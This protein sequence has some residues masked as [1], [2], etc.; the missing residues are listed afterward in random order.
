M[1]F[2]LLALF[3][4]FTNQPFY[5]RVVIK[6]LII[7]WAVFVC[8]S[9]IVIGAHFASDVIFGAFII[10]VAYLFSINKANKTLKVETD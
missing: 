5:K 1:G 3:V 8:L 10:I 6:G 4:F 2:M 7:C 9:R